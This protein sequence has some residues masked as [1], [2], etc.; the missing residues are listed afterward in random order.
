MLWVRALPRA[1]SGPY[2]DANACMQI[3]L[4]MKRSSAYSTV[5]GVVI[6]WHHYSRG[7]AS[8]PPS[9]STFLPLKGLS[10]SN[11]QVVPAMPPSMRLRPPCLEIRRS[12][13]LC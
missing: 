10:V 7:A 3:K 2:K 1:A 5:K 8:P 4:R 6:D 12:C 9:P 11:K 13:A